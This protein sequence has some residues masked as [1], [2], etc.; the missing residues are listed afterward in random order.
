MAQR[1]STVSRTAGK[2]VEAMKTS[3]AV[4]TFASPV[5]TF[6]TVDSHMMMTNSTAA[7]IQV[8]VGLPFRAWHRVE[9]VPDQHADQEHQRGDD[10]VELRANASG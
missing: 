7:T 8:Q 3:P 4:D 9:I 10:P 2:C 6:G 1:P 5:S